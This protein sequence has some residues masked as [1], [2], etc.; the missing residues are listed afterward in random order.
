[1][2]RGERPDEGAAL[3]LGAELGEGFPRL[4]FGLVGSAKLHSELIASLPELIHGHRGD[5]DDA[6][7]DVLRGV[8]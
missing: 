8:L 6:Q 2:P 3:A 7:Y 4:R 1:V 5:D